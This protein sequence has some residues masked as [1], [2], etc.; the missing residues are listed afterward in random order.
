MAYKR[1]TP[2]VEEA[3]PQEEPSVVEKPAEPTTEYVVVEAY[4]ANI[5]NKRLQGTVGQ[6]VRLTPTQYSTLKRFVL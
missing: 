3:A 5:N 2:K 1:K 6:R 4:T